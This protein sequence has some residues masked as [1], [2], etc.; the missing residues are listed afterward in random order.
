MLKV[1][2]NTSSLMVYNELG[3]LPLSIRRKIRIV[4]FWCKLLESENCIYQDM[5]ERAE[6]YPC[7]IYN[8]LLNVKKNV[9][10]SLGFGEVWYCQNVTNKKLFLDIFKQRLQDCFQQDCNAFFFSTSSKS[11]LYRYLTNKL[12]LQSY[13]LKPISVKY[14]QLFTR[15]GLSMHSLMIEMGGF[16]QLPKEQRLCMFCHLSKMSITLFL[17]V[18][19]NMNIENCT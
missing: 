4:K 17:N 14:I 11:A 12:C 3:R 9:L 7:V 10:F 2:K 13:L 8:W 18:R 5:F 16:T 15:Y 6:K 1:R 19:C